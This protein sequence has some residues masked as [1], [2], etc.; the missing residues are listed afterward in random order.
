MKVILFS[1]LMM[2]ASASQA[3]TSK[4]SCTLEKSCTSRGK[5][6]TLSTPVVISFCDKGDIIEVAARGGKT[7]RLNRIMNEE[8]YAKRPYKALKGRRLDVG[9]WADPDVATGEQN[10]ITFIMHED[11]PTAVMFRGDPLKQRG[12]GYLSGNCTQQR[13]SKCKAN[14]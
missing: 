11:T 3:E 4:L 7:T 2:L 8:P 12:L 14:E 13:V 1:A 6:E 5:C 10:L 9:Q